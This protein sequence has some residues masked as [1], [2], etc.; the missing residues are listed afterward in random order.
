M[1]RVSPKLTQPF[2][3][4]LCVPFFRFRHSDKDCPL[5]GIGFPLS[6]S[7]IVFGA[8]HFITPGLLKAGCELLILFHVHLFS[9]KTEAFS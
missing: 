5:L 1:H 6:K 8:A 9:G 3:P 4:T 2:C 7:V